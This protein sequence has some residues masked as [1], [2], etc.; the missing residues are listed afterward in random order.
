MSWPKSP[1]WD[2]S[3]DLYRRPGVEAACLDLQRRHGLNVNLLFFACWLASQG[4]EFDRTT[5]AKAMKAI[6][7]WQVEV[8]R[9]LRALRRR[10]GVRISHATP[11]SLLGRWPDQV[12]AL[13]RTALALELD[14]EH[15]TQLALSD[16]GA[17][18]RPSRKSGIDLAVLNLKHYWR[19]GPD[20]LDDL[21]TLLQQAFP[22]TT[23]AH[24][25]QAFT[26]FE[27]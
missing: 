17:G 13:R 12:A 4:I 11:E 21:K 27:V 19:F 9:P 18:L 5:L 16:I 15:L 2:Y 14:S 24:L 20:D 10:L 7:T 22:K 25:E 8:T 26:A 6:S 3:I 23:P 1:L